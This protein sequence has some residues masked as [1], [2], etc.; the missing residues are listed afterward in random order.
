ALHAVG[1]R[2]R[3][4]ASDNG[5]RG[6]AVARCFGDGEAHLAGG[7]VTDEPHGVDWLVGW[8]GADDDVPAT[9]V[10][11]RCTEERA[12]RADDGQWLGE[13]ASPH[14]ATRQAPGVGTGEGDAACAKRLD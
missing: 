5:H 6:A 9:E 11:V 1:R 7:M 8:A 10:A 14:P 3:D 4:R 13:A 2:Q 12:Q